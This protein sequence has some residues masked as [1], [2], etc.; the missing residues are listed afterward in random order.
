MGNELTFLPESV[1]SICLVL[2]K[3][4]KAALT[5]VLP[6]PFSFSHSLSPFKTQLEGLP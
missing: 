3:D 6:S 4:F 2:V 1:L 5:L